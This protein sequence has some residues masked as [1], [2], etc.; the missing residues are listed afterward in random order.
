MA[1]FEVNG[2][3]KCTGFWGFWQYLKCRVTDKR[4]LFTVIEFHSVES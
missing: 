4:K 1:V 2:V 3:V